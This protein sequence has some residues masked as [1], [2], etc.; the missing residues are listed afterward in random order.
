[1]TTMTVKIVGQ[2]TGDTDFASPE[3]LVAFALGMTLFVITLGAQHLR[4]LDRAQVSGAVRMT[5]VT[6]VPAARRQCRAPQAQS[7]LVA[8]RAMKRRNAAEARFKALRHRRHRRVSLVTLAIMLFTIF[9]D[10]VS[11]FL[12]AKLSFPLTLVG[13][14]AGPGGQPRLATRW[15][16]SRRSATSKVLGAALLAELARA[17][18][19]RNE[20]VTDKEIAELI[21]KDAPGQLRAQVLADPVA[22]RH[23]H[24]RRPSLPT[25]RIDGYLKGRVTLETA[26]RDSNVTPDQLRPGRPAARR[27]AS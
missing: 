17:R 16:R 9:R 24:R 19:S 4:P 2:L 6:A 3:T 25:G 20:G 10:G 26:E 21:S 7:I 18:A 22:G 1:M 8:R 23:H 14:S 12:Q 13:R 5:D 11:A 27:R 15:P